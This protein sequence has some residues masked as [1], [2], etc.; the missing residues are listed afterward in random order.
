MKRLI[1]T[2]SAMVIAT[3]AMAQ[4]LPKKKS[5][6]VV[7]K[8]EYYI[9]AS[10]F[11]YSPLAQSIVGNTSSQY[12]QAKLLYTWLCQNISYDKGGNTRDADA[13]FITRRAVCQGYCEL[14][15]RLAETLKLKVSLIY[16]KAKRPV[17]GYEEHVW[18]T[19]KTEKGLIIID[20]TWGAGLFVNG[21]FRHHNDPL[22][23]FDVKPE[24]LIYTHYPQNKKYQYLTTPLTE[25][26]FMDL[27]FKTPRALERG[28]RDGETKQQ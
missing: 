6:A 4:D 23:W 18:L 28:E 25:Q 27:P 11:D 3:V 8:N 20:P 9:S 5:G 13:V 21:T 26:A 24:H 16:G 22:M 14:Y 15:Y 19:V 7:Y 1:L 10:S 17:G 2:I 12:E